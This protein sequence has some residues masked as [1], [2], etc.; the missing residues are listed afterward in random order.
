[1]LSGLLTVGGRKP[2][3]HEA[4]DRLDRRHRK[5]PVEV[6]FDCEQIAVGLIPNLRPVVHSHRVGKVDSARLLERGGDQALDIEFL[7]LINISHVGTSQSKAALRRD[8]VLLFAGVECNPSESQA[9]SLRKTAWR[10]LNRLGG[11][12]G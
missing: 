9:L 10:R 11:K 5:W 2:K 1:M 12:H 7:A 4:K 6:D 3:P 8:A